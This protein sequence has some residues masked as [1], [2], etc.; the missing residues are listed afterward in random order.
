[1]LSDFDVDTFVSSVGAFGEVAA[2]GNVFFFF[3]KDCPR[4]EGNISITGC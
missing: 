3:C 1:M 4:H 2:S